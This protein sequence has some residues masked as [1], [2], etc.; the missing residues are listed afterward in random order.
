MRTA[1]LTDEL[2]L[3]RALLEQA[4]ADVTKAKKHEGLKLREFQVEL[5]E[6]ELSRDQHVRAFEQAQSAP[7][8]ATSRTT[9]ADERHQRACERIG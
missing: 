9:D 7:Q 2:A 4:E 8:K 6:L 3:K 5:D 1:Q